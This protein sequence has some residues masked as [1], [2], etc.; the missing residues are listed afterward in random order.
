[1]FKNVRIGIRL[2][3]LFLVVG[4]LPLLVLGGYTDTV[5]E[6]AIMAQ[7]FAQLESIRQIK[8]ARIDKYFEDSQRDI[9]SMA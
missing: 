4:I 8:K 5:A 3:V 6:D 7:A 2:S 9:Q 1:M